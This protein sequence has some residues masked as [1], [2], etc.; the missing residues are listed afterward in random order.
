MKQYTRP[1]WDE[2]F[3][4][5]AYDAATRSSCHNLH[6]GVALVKDKRVIATGYNGAPPGIENCLQRGCRKKQEKVGFDDKGKGVCRGTHA[7]MNAIGQVS[8]ELT[9]KATIYTV[10]FPC[11][12]CAKQIA[13]SGVEEV[14][15]D[16]VYTEADSLTQEI[17][18]EA[19][20]KLRRLDFNMDAQN[21]RRQ[22]VKD[23]AKKREVKK[24]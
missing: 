24:K 6:T 16:Q 18:A 12:A 23:Q 19:G 20:I 14:V 10:Y 21:K 11:S 8:R 7:E 15:Y 2:S 17:F 5:I 1:S 9:K 4:S 3:M 22:V 13:G